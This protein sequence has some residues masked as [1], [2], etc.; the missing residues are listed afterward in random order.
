M[1][2]AT[3]KVLCFINAALVAGLLSSCGE[4]KPTFSLLPDSNLFKQGEGTINNKLDILWVIDNSG[5]MAPYQANIAANLNA[6][7]GNFVTKGY[8]F[9]IAVTT[10][11]AW[12]AP[13]GNAN[14]AKFRDGT[15]AT[16]HT[17]FFVVDPL[18]AN[19]INVLDVNLTQ[20]TSGSGDERAFSSFKEALNSNLNAGFLRNDSFLAIIIVSDEDDFS[21][22]SQ[23]YIGHDYN[24]PTLET[25]NSYVSYLDTLTNT[26]GGNRRYSVS[27]MADIDAACQAA[28]AST[29]SIIGQRYID[30]VDA[31]NGIKGSLCSTDFSNEL[32]QIQN[33]IAELS[34]QF[35]LT[36]EPI[37]TS[38][39]IHVN[40]VLIPEDDINGWSYQADINAIRFHGT[41]IPPQGASISVNFDPVTI[42]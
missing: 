42:K 21:H 6:F 20:G 14:I 8:D 9:K 39:V 41:D 30:L 26:T 35:F 27:A 29:G 11:E 37:P 3:R 25:V 23:A 2:R 22:P 24:E 28:K 13:Y 34:T 12:L 38:I 7:L 36:R 1:L 31:T 40:G 5:S 17:G 10:T 33:K 18:T 4:E 32:N 19:L 15:N 16:S